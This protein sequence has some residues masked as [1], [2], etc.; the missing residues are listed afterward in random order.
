MSNP[1]QL[2]WQKNVSALTR[3]KKKHFD[4]TL[5]SLSTFIGASTCLRPEFRPNYSASLFS[6]HVAALWLKVSRSVLDPRSPFE[7]FTVLSLSG[8]ATLEQTSIHSFRAQNDSQQSP[9]RPWHKL[10]LRGVS[11]RPMIS[12]RRTHT[13]IRAIGV[14]HTQLAKISFDISDLT[15]VQYSVVLFFR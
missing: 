11:R 15:V 10:A 7:V 14:Y 8:Q 5:C 6:Q 12:L 13:V 4:P 2:K 3:K 9:C 1:K